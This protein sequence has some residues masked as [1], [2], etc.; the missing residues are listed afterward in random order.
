MHKVTRQCPQTTTFLKR[1]ES[2]SGIEPRSFRLPAQRLTA[3]PRRLTIPYH[4]IL[5]NLLYV[6]I[7]KGDRMRGIEPKWSAH[8]PNALPLGQTDSPDQQNAQKWGRRETS[9]LSGPRSYS[10]C[11][12]LLPPLSHTNSPCW[13]VVSAV[14]PPCNELHQLLLETSLFFFFFLLFFFG[15]GGG[16]AEEDFFRFFFFDSKSLT[17]FIFF[18][19][20]FFLFCMRRAHWLCVLY[21]TRG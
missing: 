10:P 4:S 21:S 18:F 3:R 5:F 1:K 20:S 15:G 6:W 19:S 13:A 11:S 7:E 12:S 9:Q 16:G 14:V 8:Q 2:R 17:S